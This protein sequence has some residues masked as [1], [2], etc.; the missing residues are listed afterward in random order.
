MRRPLLLTADVRITQGG[1]EIRVTGHDHRIEVSPSSIR[2]LL[3]TF[4]R[5]S[6][7]TYP[8]VLTLDQILRDS[9]LTVVLK[10]QYFRL[11]ILGVNARKWVRMVLRC[12][13]PR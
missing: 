6:A 3:K 12:I 7:V 4:R 2:F 13:L 10:S 11:T 9:G 5:A 1:Q 8:R